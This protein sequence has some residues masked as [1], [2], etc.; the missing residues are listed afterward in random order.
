MT[1]QS[2]MLLVVYLVVLLALAYPMGQFLAKVGDG[3]SI[4]GWGWMAKIEHFLYRIAGV[5]SAAGMS[6]KTYSIALLV[7][8]A[9]GVL[10]VYAIQ[11]LQLWLPLNPQ[12]FANVSPDS[13][14]NTA[15]SFASNTNW[16][17]YSG[18]ATMSYL[19]Q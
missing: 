9:L 5:D 10:F 12:A 4:R 1:T 7:F 16:Q 14:F 6:W 8:N 19:T 15:V 2:L 13:A 11:R 3:S 17:G 18:E